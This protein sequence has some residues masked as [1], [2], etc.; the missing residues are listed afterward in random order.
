MLKSCGL[1]RASP[2]RFPGRKVTWKLDRADKTTVLLNPPSPI[3]TNCVSA[4]EPATAPTS[5]GL[6]VKQKLGGDVATSMCTSSQW[7]RLV[8]FASTCELPGPWG[9]RL[10]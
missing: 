6:A 1:V 2:D 9:D 5:R 7:W 3:V 4:E 10:G 8:L